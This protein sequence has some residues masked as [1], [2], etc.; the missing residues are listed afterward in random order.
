M[1]TERQIMERKEK[2]IDSRMIAC[3]LQPSMRYA[4]FHDLWISY[5]SLQVAAKVSQTKIFLISAQISSLLIDI[6]R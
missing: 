5:S 3:L 6:N 2:N 4:G 1:S